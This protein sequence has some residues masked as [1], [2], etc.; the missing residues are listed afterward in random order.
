MRAKA[1][2]KIKASYRP[3]HTPPSPK[4]RKLFLIDRSAHTGNRK[5]ELSTNIEKCP[6]LKFKIFP[7]MVR[8]RA[9]IRP[10]TYILEKIA[11]PIS[12]N[13]P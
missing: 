7:F 11:N 9:E 6:I 3:S 8:K 12:I 5:A 13:K 4:A 1:L 10:Y 2:E